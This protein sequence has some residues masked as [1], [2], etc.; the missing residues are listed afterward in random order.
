MAAGAYGERSLKETPSW[1]V[2][3]VCAVFII[4][5]IVIERGI[6][7]LA[8][9]HKK[10]MIEALEKLKAELMLL[11][12]ISLLITVGTKPI[13]KICIPEKA[14]NIMLPCK[15]EIKKDSDKGEPGDKDDR[16]KL[17]WYAGD[18]I[19]HRL[20]AA[21]AGGDDYCSQKGKVS[22]ISQSGVHQLHIFIFVL[23]VFHVIYSVVII[24]LAKAKMKRWKSWESETSSLE[25][26]FTNDPSRFRFTRQTSFVKRHTGLSATPG[27]R[28]IVAFFRQFFASVTKVDYLTLR[29]GFINAHFAPNSKFNFHNYI[30]RS[31]EDDFKVVVGI[32]IPLWICSVIFQLLNVYGW[33]TLTWLPFVPLAVILIVGAKL[34]IIIMEM[35]HEIQDKTTVVKGVP[36]V[37]PSNKY[38]WFNRPE[39]ILFLIHFTLFQMG[40][41]MK[42][43]IFEE[44]TSKAIK[45]W[46]K[47]AK[48][49]KKLRMKA[50]A[51]CSSKGFS[52][53]SPDNQSSTPS[54]GT[55]PLHLLHKFKHNST[56]LEGGLSTC[57]SP[58]SFYSETELSEI[59]G[60]P[61]SS[62]DYELR[63]QKNPKR[64]QESRSADF[65]F[66]M[67]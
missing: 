32:S 31:M 50:E 52:M 34:E 45:K 21:A 6:H 9:R 5:S 7:S 46:Q 67:P 33:Y 4:I 57:T 25:Y 22:L 10:A 14:G 37:E 16:R 39:I 20:L 11:G 48:D 24:A 26:Q 43:A 66:A 55:S 23:A 8:K 47:S 15:K 17:L 59:E 49:R 53:M 60:A 42:K 1:A 41:H 36:V 65:S 63:R 29:H 40:S 12:F 19:S 27:L 38:F 62:D 13:S 58:R 28:W 64:L 2:A 61:P 3:L 44:Q 54:K 18:A 56:D 35:A 30:K 51:D